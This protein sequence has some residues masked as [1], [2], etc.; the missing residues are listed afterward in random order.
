MIFAIA[1]VERLKLAIES[2]VTVRS[3]PDALPH[4]CVKNRI[5][6]IA[7]VERLELAIEGLVTVRSSPDS[8]GALFDRA[9][10]LL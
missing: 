6:A 5:F 7:P 10:T 8:F 1:P 3:S 9:L 2:V 4:P